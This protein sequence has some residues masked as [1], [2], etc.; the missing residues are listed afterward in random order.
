MMNDKEHAW[1]EG[2]QALLP[3][4]IALRRRI[5][6]NPELGLDLPLT[7]QS[8]LDSLKGLD[9]HI[10]RGRSTSGVMVTL[11]GPSQGGTVLLRGDMDALP[12]QEDTGLNFASKQPGRMHACG[13]DAHTAMLTGA[14]KLLH[15]NRA[16]LAGSVKFMFQ[17]GEEGYHGALRMIEDGLLDGAP[18]PDA[19]FAIHVT[20]NAPAGVVTSKAGPIMASTDEVQITIWGKGGHAALPYLALDPIPIAAEIVTALQAMVTRRVNPFDPVIL[21]IAKI[22]AGT[23]RNVV[24]ETAQLLGTLRSLSET[25]RKVAREGITRVATKVAEAHGARAEVTLTPGYNV[26]VNDGRMAALAA[27][28]AR[29]ALGEKNFVRMQAPIMGAEDFS[30]V[31]ERMP[32]CM[33]FLGVSPIANHHE[34]APIHSNRMMLEERAM[35]NGIALYAAVAERYLERGLPAQ[36]D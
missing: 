3:E 16:R 15:A 4:T 21:T 31:L 20:T 27:D 24:P 9:V 32:G 8:V 30:Y 2:A 36:T 19:A 22:E 10:E 23:T 13:H 14:V 1:S 29:S 17:P 18:K 25:S 5:H 28:A 33:V 35:A 34:A 11:K 6:E 26:T 7:T 12:M